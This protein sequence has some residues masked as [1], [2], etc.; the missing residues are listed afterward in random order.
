MR[1]GIYCGSADILFVDIL[2]DELDARHIERE[3]RPNLK[4]Y[5]GLR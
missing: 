2:S 5:T 1:A 4:N 3:G